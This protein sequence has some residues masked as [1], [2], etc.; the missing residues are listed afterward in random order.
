MV[1]VASFSYADGYKIKVTIHGVHD[2]VIYLGNHYGDK[3]YARDTV[4]LDKNGTGIFKGDK[5]LEGGIYLV[6]VPSRDMTYFE[7]VIDKDQEFAM[8]TD[9]A[10]YIR[11]MKIT[12]SE[13]N[14]LFYEFQNKMIDLQHKAMSI[15]ER[16][17]KFT[18]KDDS[19]KILKDE[20]NNVTKEKDEYWNSI[21][22]K[23]PDSFIS[24]LLKAMKDP[25]IPEFD[26]PEDASNP[27]SIRRVKTYLYAKEHYFD[28]IDFSDSRILRTPIFHTKLN[29]FMKK[30]VLQHPDSIIKEGDRLVKMAEADSNMFRYVL[31]YMLGYYENT[32]IMGM[33][34]V[35]V[36]FGE[37]YYLNDKAYWADSTLK[38]KIAERVIALKPNLLGQKAPDLILETYKGRPITMSQI[39]ADYL[40]L[41]FFDPSCGHCKKETP[42]LFDLYEKFKKY[43][44]EVLCVYTQ[45]DMKEWKE[46]LE[47]HKFEWIN[48]WDKY[49][50]SNF[51]T[52]YDIYSTPVAYVLDKDKNIIA[53]RIEVHQIEELLK[54]LLKIEDDSD[55][56][57]KDE[58]K[59]D[60]G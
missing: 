54:D 17:K 5:A 9:T 58:Q 51:R 45:H 57:E 41:Y 31:V 42:V 22:K 35:F 27:D 49:G 25:E 7:L 20:L 12:G 33:D 48:A 14:K 15:E 10:D 21:I 60:N 23:Y 26:I 3:K 6:L 39:K 37:N 11:H 8:E 53:K 13:E 43:K 59:E 30:M 38:A 47:K 44:V 1:I 16:M 52:K 50:M 56:I 46:Y 55:S 36:H 2:T 18:E 34:K 40:I 19:L 4:M 29:T 32:K 28:N 24:V